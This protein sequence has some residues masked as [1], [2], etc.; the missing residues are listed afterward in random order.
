MTSLAPVGATTIIGQAP[1]ATGV[2]R[3][4][5]LSAVTTPSSTSVTL[6]QGSATPLTYTPQTASA[7]GASG[8]TWERDA[9]D[10]VSTV[11]AATVSSRSLAGRLEGVASALL[12]R[13]KTDGGNFSQ[14]VKLPQAT[15]Q[16]DELTGAT[17]AA[18]SGLDD[19]SYT[20]RITTASGVK[21][22]VT[23][24]SSADGLAVQ[25]EVTDGDLSEDERK[26]IAGLSK[27]FQDAVDGLASVPP[28]MAWSG[29]AKFDT[30]VLSSV[31]LQATSSA[32]GVLSQSVEFSADSK[33]RSLTFKSADGVVKVD[34][35]VSKSA[36]YGNAQQRAAAVSDYLQQFE[37]ARSRGRGDEALMGLFK[38]AFTE[39]H[40][41][42]E[43]GAAP[44][45]QAP[46]RVAAGYTYRSLLSGVADF[47]ASVSQTMV[48]SNPYK[49]REF[50]QFSYQVSQSSS[51]SGRPLFDLSVKQEQRANLTASFHTGL[52]P[53]HQLD[54]TKESKSQ[55]YRYYQINDEVSS[56]TSIRYE[57]GALAAATLTHT[58]NLNT[59]MQAYVKAELVE[60]IN[61]PVSDTKTRDLMSLVRAADLEPREDDRLLRRDPAQLDAMLLDKHVALAR[62]VARERQD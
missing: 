32:N 5:P 6:G 23:L 52:T 57:E 10:P 21:V 61:T 13:F 48:A 37:A 17:L 24:G 29:L 44:S 15:G 41:T 26:A 28:R 36:V 50:D 9:V 62:S 18:P 43:A 19:D 31:S 2:A 42:Y 39:L 45:S 14:S 1:P 4:A 53:Q 27:S 56:Q 34:I 59:R 58:R 22:A 60:D 16:V 12:D 11:I 51:I 55:N 8:L 30:S 49:T 38:D 20:L 25:I 47:S 54:L 35:D 33:Q 46:R 7:V 40:Q 3:A